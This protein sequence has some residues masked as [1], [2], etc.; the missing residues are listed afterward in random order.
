MGLLNIYGGNNSKK[1]KKNPAGPFWSPF[2]FADCRPGRRYSLFL[3][4]QLKSLVPPVCRDKQA[5]MMKRGL[6]CVQ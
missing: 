5:V 3:K 4:D 6:V 2:S 1:G